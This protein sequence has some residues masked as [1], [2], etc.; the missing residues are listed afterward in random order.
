MT[1]RMSI[2]FKRFKTCG[3][4]LAGLLAASCSREPAGYGQQ[5][6]SATPLAFDAYVPRV[7]TRAGVAGDVTTTGFNSGDLG[8]AGFGVFGYYTG[9]GSLGSDSQ[10]NFMYNQQVKKSGGNWS[11]APVKYWPNEYP[12]ALS[13][14]TDHVS[15][16][17]YAPYV[18]V[19]RA[20]GQLD[21]AS[22]LAGADD[23]ATGIVSLSAL[24]DRG[25]PLVNYVASADPAR[26]VDLCWATVADHPDASN[27]TATFVYWGYPS[28]R[29]RLDGGL[30]WLNL[31]R[32]PSVDDRI[33]FVFRHAT[34]K[35]NVQIDAPSDYVVGDTRV[36]V[37]EVT[38]TGMAM[39][40]AL[41]LNN[42]TAATAQWVGFDGN[43]RI[44]REAVT[45]CD[46]RQDGLEGRFADPGEGLTGINPNLIQ[47]TAWG[48][49]SQK[50]GVTATAMNLFGSGA[51]ALAPIY[52]IPNG[53]P[54]TVTLTYDI[55]TADSLP[56][57]VSDGT[58]RG[59]SIENR[60]S[61]AIRNGIGDVVM[62]AGKSYT[63][64]LHVGLNGLR[65][66]VAV[67]DDW[68]YNVEDLTI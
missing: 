13:S 31:T 55:E 19:I 46:G 57:T 18:D 66:D 43:G 41:N 28:A 52:V 1:Y 38:F 4:V 29:V 54:L 32:A 48:D 39:E 3:L 42:R 36:Y 25:D 12:D 9:S 26:A 5:G 45:I 65:F 8:A 23:T 56:G 22:A 17:A 16:F 62:E 37:R 50:D 33:G 67:E 35:L 2:N 6:A 27:P 53:Q 21:A 30:P 11:Y 10:P 34:A 63:L 49:A 40:G 61:L 7:V 15:F 51:D 64:L 60:S 58:T 24:A 59:V 47:D 44:S 20:T 14:E 68:D